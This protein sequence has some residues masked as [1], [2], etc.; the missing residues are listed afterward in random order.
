MGDADDSYDF[1]QLAPFLEY[2]RWGDDLVMGNRYRSGIRPSAMLWLH[3]YVGKPFLTH[4]LNLFF[5][6]PIGDSQS[7]K[8]AEGGSRRHLLVDVLGWRTALVVHAA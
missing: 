6:S 2:L 1:G 3:C 7:V 4:L 8:T 5:R